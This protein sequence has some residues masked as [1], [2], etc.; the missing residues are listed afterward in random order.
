VSKKKLKRRI[1]ALENQVELMISNL[2]T[3]GAWIDAVDEWNEIVSVA[4]TKH[5]RDNA[6]LEGLNRALAEAVDGD[7]Q[8]RD[9]RFAILRE[10]VDAH[11]VLVNYLMLKDMGMSEEEMEDFLKSD[12]PDEDNDLEE[13]MGQYLGLDVSLI[14]AE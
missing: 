13:G 6:R 7:Q 12:S 4:L 2:D 10:L 3:T 14:P 9:K 1:K 5:E 8:D 11:A